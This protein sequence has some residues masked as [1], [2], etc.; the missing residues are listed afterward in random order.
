MPVAITSTDEVVPGHA[1]Q[2]SARQI[3]ESKDVEQGY[4]DSYGG[5]DG[6]SLASELLY[7]DSDAVMDSPEGMYH[8]SLFRPFSLNGAQ[9]LNP[10]YRAH[11]SS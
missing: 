5:A 8:R 10:T 7:E 4:E 1:D 6:D 3:M 9:P 2:P 11:Y